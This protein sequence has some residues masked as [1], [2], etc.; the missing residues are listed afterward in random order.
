MEIWQRW[1]RSEE[2][3]DKWPVTRG[4]IRLEDSVACIMHRFLDNLFLN[5]DPAVGGVPDS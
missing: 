2:D 3:H 5:F 1:A 4:V